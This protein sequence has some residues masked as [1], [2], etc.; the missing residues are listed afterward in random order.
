MTLLVMLLLPTMGAAGNGRVYTECRLTNAATGK[1]LTESLIPA[2][3][4][5]L[6][7]FEPGDGAPR[8]LVGDPTETRSVRCELYPFNE[9]PR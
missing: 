9:A 3:A 1:E 5:L 7:G 4:P 8:L 2:P 6:L